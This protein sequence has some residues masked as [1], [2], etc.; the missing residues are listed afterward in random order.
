[1]L[2][3]TF[4]RSRL[5]PAGQEAYRE[6]VLGLLR[7]QEE[8]PL[9]AGIGSRED[10][11]QLLRAV[12]LDHPELF[13]VDFWNAQSL[14]RGADLRL[15]IPMLLEEETALAVGKT[16]YQRA[17]DLREP[18]RQAPNRAQAY[19]LLAREIGANTRY[20]NTGSTF[21]EHTAAGPVL[22]HRSVCEG[23]AKLFLFYCQRLELPC[24]LV[25]GELQGVPHAWNVVEPEGEGKYIDVTALLQTIRL[26]PPISGVAFQR[27]E[28]LRRL[29]YSW[30]SR[31]FR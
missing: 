6:I 22:C 3:P 9:P 7:R 13:Y 27:E 8:I 4:Y 5:S 30:D 14:Q 17:E 19:F 28:T 21:W 12:H 23:I 26:L 1:M 24:A 18:V 10:L 2:P 15:C 16:L 11:E 31:I 20:V 25:T 29:G